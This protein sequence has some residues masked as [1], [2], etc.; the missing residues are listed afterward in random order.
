MKEKAKKRVIYKR[1][2]IYMSK[3]L[4]EENEKYNEEYIYAKKVK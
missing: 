2:I 1:Y 3:L 4:L